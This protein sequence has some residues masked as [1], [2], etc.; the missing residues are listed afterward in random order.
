MCGGGG[1]GG[2]K[3]IGV[4]IQLNI[5]TWGENIERYFHV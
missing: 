3:I 1:G 5:F 4:D 2:E